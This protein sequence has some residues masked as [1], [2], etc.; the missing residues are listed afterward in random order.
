MSV[1]TWFVEFILHLDE[2]LGGIIQQYGAFTYVL[3]F[4]IIFCETGLVVMPFLPGDSLLFAAGAFAAV[5]AFHVGWLFLLLVGAAILGDTVNYLIGHRLGR[6]V[7]EKDYRWLNKEH[8][9]RAEEFYEKHGGKT[10][11]LARFIP[12]IRTFAPFVAG[13]GK[14]HYRKFIAYNVAGGIAWVGLFVFGGYFFGNLPWVKANFSAV[15]L[16]IIVLSLVPLV[17]EYFKHMKSK[18]QEIK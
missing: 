11:I 17:V 9:K 2:R 15:I 7:F 18:K 12:I 14:M 3:L 13:V 6:S 1:F 16:A 4:L 5:G 10:I 8:L